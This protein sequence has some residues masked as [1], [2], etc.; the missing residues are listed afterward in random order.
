MSQFLSCP[1]RKCDR[2]NAASSFQVINALQDLPTPQG[3]R[4]SGLQIS[5]PVKHHLNRLIN[6]CFE[7]W[8]TELSSDFTQ[9][10]VMLRHVDYEE[11]AQEV[12]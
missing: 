1:S 7:P 3:N 11:D 9:H 8:P 12:L 10:R 2:R 6:L 5:D 4:I